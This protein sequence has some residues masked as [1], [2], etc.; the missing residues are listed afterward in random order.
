M[1][2]L[3]RSAENREVDANMTQFYANVGS[4]MTALQTER[5]KAKTAKGIETSSHVSDDKEDQTMHDDS[6]KQESPHDVK[7]VTGPLQSPRVGTSGKSKRAGGS[8]F[9]VGDSPAA[10]PREKKTKGP[11]AVASVP[12]VP[13]S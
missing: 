5:E 13:L 7:D 10:A 11:N 9:K 4:S 2:T 1:K 12:S 3:V 8:P 6:S